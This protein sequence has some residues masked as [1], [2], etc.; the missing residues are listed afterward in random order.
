MR[1]G[2]GAERWRT[3]HMLTFERLP[4]TPDNRALLDFGS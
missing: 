1:W 3:A 2:E 4:D